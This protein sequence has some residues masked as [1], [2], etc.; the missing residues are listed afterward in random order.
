MPAG[1]TLTDMAFVVV[2]GQCA[3]LLHPISFSVLH[4]VSALTPLSS[5]FYFKCKETWL[6]CDIEKIIS[7]TL[8]CD[9]NSD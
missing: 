9:L 8:F 2:A 3:L 5:I 7:Y 1:A 4:T 6:L